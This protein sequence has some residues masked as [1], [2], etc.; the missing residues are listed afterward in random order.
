M[1]IRFASERV[2]SKQR[3]KAFMVCLGLAGIG[4]FLGFA[5]I[6][7]EA[8]NAIP[9]RSY[10]YLN[11]QFKNADN[12]TYHYQVRVD[13]DIVGQILNPR[14][15]HGIATVQLQMAPSVAPL[16]SDTTMQVLPRSAVGV[17]YL[18]VTP[19]LNGR[20]LPSG[21][22]IPYTQTS[23]TV[24]IDTALSV[25]NPATRRNI[26]YFLRSFGEGLAGQGQNLN[27]T[28]GAS[29][30]FLTAGTTLLSA[31]SSHPGSVRSLIQGGAT[32]ANATLPVRQ[33]AAT[34]FHPEALALKPFQDASGI[35]GTLTQAPPALSTL[36]TKLPAFD[37]LA[38]QMTG[39]ANAIAPGLKAGPASFSQTSALLTEA[40]P[41]LTFAKQVLHTTGVAVNPVLALLGTIQP[42]L[43]PLKTGLLKAQP[44]VST[45]GAHG[46]DFIRFGVHWTS[47]QQ[48]GNAQGNVLRFQI[49]SPDISSFY[50][51]TVKTP[52]TFTNP[53]PAP[54][55]SGTEKLP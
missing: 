38:Q 14:V 8:P 40:R 21:S 44:I 18:E 12:L 37:A 39:F 5:L 32:M 4:V 46:C 22:T 45:L 23:S 49:N 15:S 3:S 35:D 27:D 1:K 25:F 36:Q 34:G 52:T 30:Q 20:K 2:A 13:G 9:G 16:R 29:P 10:Y 17:R 24:Q 51:V 48:Y 28:L 55:V 54:C 6:G 11:A 33:V 50:G 43:T 26:Q 42:V 47:M 7:F 41:S 53:Y 31:I 19:G